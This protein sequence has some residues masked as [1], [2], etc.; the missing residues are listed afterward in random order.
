LGEG[1]ARDRIVF[2]FVL[3]E[4]LLREQRADPT[5]QISYAAVRRM[6]NAAWAA[7]SR[8]LPKVSETLL[9][10]D[11]TRIDFTGVALKEIANIL[12][13]LVKGERSWPNIPKPG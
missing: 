6:A 10:D 5:V 12:V 13:V 7:G 4:N 9:T 1:I 11:V 8:A 3:R 2:T